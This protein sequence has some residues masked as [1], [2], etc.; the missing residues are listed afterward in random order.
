MGGSKG[1]A[2][3]PRSIRYFRCTKCD[4]TGGTEEFKDGC[5]ACGGFHIVHERCAPVLPAW[6][7]C[8]VVDFNRVR[9]ETEAG[10]L[11]NRV[12]EI[13]FAAS[14]LSLSWNEI[15]ARE[16]RGLQILWDE[17]NKRR[18]ELDKRAHEENE[19]R[20]RMNPRR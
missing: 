11:L 15:T 5:P 17:R 6:A 9:G 18:A 8:P 2:G 16:A 1:A 10:R 14:N 20:A 13:D 12:L 7:G 19:R 3:C 4:V